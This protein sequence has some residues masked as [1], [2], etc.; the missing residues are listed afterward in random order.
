[1]QQMNGH[2]EGVRSKI[3]HEVR[4]GNIMIPELGSNINTYKE[5]IRSK[6]KK[7][8]HEMSKANLEPAIFVQ[9]N[10]CFPGSNGEFL[11]VGKMPDSSWWL[12]RQ[13]IEQT[14]ASQIGSSPQ[15]KRGEN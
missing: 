11:M 15:K 12:N 2:L 14:C 3:M 1:M 4:V 9:I 13:P 6:G 5:R 7:R 8:F 10:I